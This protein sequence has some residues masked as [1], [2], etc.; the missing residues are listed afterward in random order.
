LNES[1]PHLMDRI[2]FLES[3]LLQTLST[4]RARHAV[5]LPGTLSSSGGE[6][7][8]SAR[9]APEILFDLIVSNPPYIG[10]RE[11]DTLEREV[12]DHEPAVAL[13][14][15]E[16]GYEFYAELITQSAA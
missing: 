7:T 10:R 9:T 12:R 16:E 4:E 1:I 8:H 3:D 11:A 14:G 13:F 5:P 15:G 2:S 6:R